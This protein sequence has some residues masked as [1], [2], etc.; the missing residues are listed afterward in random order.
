MNFTLRVILG[1]LLAAALF[2]WLAYTVHSGSKPRDPAGPAGVAG[3]VQDR[4][5]AQESSPG[6]SGGRTS[7][8]V[9]AHESAATRAMK[10]GL[11]MGQA[12]TIYLMQ[13][14]LAPEVLAT[15]RG[16]VARVLPSGVLAVVRT[17][18]PPRVP[19]RPH[20]PQ[21]VIELPEGALPLRDPAIRGA[22]LAVLSLWSVDRRPAGTM[23][24]DQVLDSEQE[25]ALRRWLR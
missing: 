24:F 16:P 9:R 19:T 11:P 21:A 10:S 15:V 4:A 23:R 18:P 25:S 1:G 6:T 12:D 13:G 14:S 2:A 3:G 7:K 5:S 20:W 17:M 22:T 8:P